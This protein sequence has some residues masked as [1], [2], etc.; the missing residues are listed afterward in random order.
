VELIHF[1]PALVPSRRAEESWLWIA[2]LKTVT[3]AGEREMVH[4]NWGRGGFSNLPATA[5]IAVAQVADSF[6]VI[7][8]SSVIR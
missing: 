1:F 7:G 6:I 4:G 5:T 2:R 8:C 3:S